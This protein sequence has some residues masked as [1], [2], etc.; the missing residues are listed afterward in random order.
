VTANQSTDFDVIIIGGGP[1]GATLGCLLGMNGHRALIVEKDI[2]PRD[3]VG[4]SITPSTN[5][6][7]KR[8]GFLE[9]VEEAG[10]VHKPGAC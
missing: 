2:H 6:I 9:K 3:H 7:F 8:I 1:A 5:P 4:E 10:F